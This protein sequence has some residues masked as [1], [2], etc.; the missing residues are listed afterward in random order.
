[1]QLRAAREVSGKTQV[2]VA[3]E[4]QISESQYQNIEYDKCEPGVRTA[5]RIAKALNSTVENLFGAAT[6]DKKKE[7][8]GNPAK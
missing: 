6:P 2:Q 7:P 4:A 8:D 5:I 3:K 1:M